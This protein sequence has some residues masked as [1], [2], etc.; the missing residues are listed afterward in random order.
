[1]TT[2]ITDDMPRPALDL[3]VLLKPVLFEHHKT[4]GD[5]AKRVFLSEDLW[6]PLKQATVKFDGSVVVCE[7]PFLT[8]ET[9]L[10]AVVLDVRGRVRSYNVHTLERATHDLIF[11]EHVVLYTAELERLEAD[12]VERGAEVRESRRLL[13]DEVLARRVAQDVRF[14]GPIHDD[15][16]T[17]VEFLNFIEKQTRQAYEIAETQRDAKGNAIAPEAAAGQIRDRLIDAAALCLAAVESYD[18]IKNDRHFIPMVD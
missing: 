3:Y 7:A 5:V 17:V 11:E 6:L 12:L 16:H 8:W 1:M 4:T 14:G 13:C 2:P 9:E 15:Q 18:R 10:T